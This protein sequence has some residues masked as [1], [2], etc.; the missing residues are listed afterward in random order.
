MGSTLVSKTKRAGSSP[1]ILVMSYIKKE[2]KANRKQAELLK[3]TTEHPFHLV[4]SSP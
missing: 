2:L 4:D 1:A 3:K